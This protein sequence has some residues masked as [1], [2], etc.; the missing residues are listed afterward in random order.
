MLQIYIHRYLLCVGYTLI[1]IAF[2]PIAVCNNDT[3]RG[4]P[5]FSIPLPSKS[6][7]DTEFESMQLCFE[8]HGE[9]GNHY[10]LVS[11]ECTSVTAEYSQG[12]VDTSLNVIT[13]IGVKAQGSNG[14]CHNIEV[15]LDNCSAYLDGTRVNTSSTVSVNGV[16]MTI[17]RQRVRVS[18]PNCDSSERLTMWMICTKRRDDNMLE[19]VIAHCD[20][21]Q[22]TA[23]GLIGMC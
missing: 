11:D 4:D 16:T 6:I 5:L 3:V 20:G 19:L 18:V 15:D 22:P 1:I 23:H 17:R 13:K 12:A 9:S 21:L 10:N 7:A 2:I 14:T 8:V